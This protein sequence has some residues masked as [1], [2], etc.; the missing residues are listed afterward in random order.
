MPHTRAT[1]SRRRAFALT[2]APM[3]ALALAA[4][5][6]GDTGN[7]PP[8][9][10]TLGGP[11]H[12][13]MY[14]SGM[15]ID[16]S[17]GSVVVADTGNN[18]V[19]KYTAA[20][21]PVWRVG[22]HGSGTNQFLNPRDVGVDSAGFVYVADSRNSRIV[23]LDGLTGA[24]VTS[25][26][27]P[28]GDKIS[29]PLGVSVTGDKVYLA[30]TAKNKVR[31]FDTAGT[32]L[33]SFATNTGTC[34]FSA[35]RDADA[36]SAGNIYLAN[37]KVNNI[38]KF[39]PT[40]T[41][42]L[43][44]GATGSADGQFRTP[45]GVRTRF[46]PVLGAELVYVADGNNNRIQMFRTDGS[47]VG[48]LGSSGPATSP[49]TFFQLRRVAVAADGDVWGADLWGWRVERFDRTLTGWAYEQTIG[50]PLPASTPGAVFQEPRG[51]AF[52]SSGVAV[53]ADTVH[54]R[55]V[56][57]NP[58]GSIVGMCGSRGSA[59]GQFNWPRGV[60]VDQA[61]G[62]IW[63]ANT[64]QYN[65]HIIRPDCSPVTKFGA[66][67]SQPENF[68]WPYSIAIRQADRIAWVAD[69]QNHRVKSYDVA[70]RAVIA[71]FGT[72]GAGANQFNEPSG[73]AVNPANGRILV[74]DAKNNRVVELADT[75]GGAISVTRTFT[76]FSLP[77]GVAA[78]FQGRIFV[79][80]SGNSRVV[81]LGADG[82]VQATFS[83]PSGFDTPEN[84]A[85]DPADN[86]LVS[87]T[88]NDRVQV[89]GPLGSPP[90]PDSTPPDST[91]T[92]PTPDQVFASGPVAMGG[93]A[94][95]N[96][97]VAS[98]RVAIKNRD[99]GLWWH[100]DGTFGT[101]QTQLTTLA[102]PGATTTAWSYSW[103]AP[104]GPG[105]YAVVVEAT[106][107]AA[108][109]EPPPKPNVLFSVSS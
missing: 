53:V 12:A 10:R 8:F 64:K 96:V 9:L 73:I 95:D 102:S 37:Y 84:V 98:V 55:V 107:G 2:L 39:S 21:V 86:L 68:N 85:V 48:K 22:G 46:D 62:E 81:A 82:I 20:G 3:V 72:K 57:M 101:Y 91:A 104:P 15:E 47:F 67:G 83:G 36:D 11:L 109:K 54:H 42:L 90:S 77:N 35:P 71:T 19:A 78:D 87:D 65:L 44:W 61:T 88:Y 59:A 74:A 6:A 80:D 29:F 93:N 108:N 4:S 27:G 99:T 14:P 92:A 69:T 5:A 49:G 50:P 18:Q 41:C 70:T 94:T 45:Y 89:Y 26:S 105:N 66:L 31:V 30:D 32:Q 33:L 58:D 40:G 24:W 51:I 25:F 63:V 56:R 16:P 13:E 106:D 60:A 28:S 100:A 7:P 1:L 17:D 34:A 52:E 38:A 103:P 23:K 43:A 75:G 79:A 97:G 76:G